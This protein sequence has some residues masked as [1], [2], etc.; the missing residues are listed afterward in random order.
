MLPQLNRREQM[1]HSRSGV[2]MLWLLMSFFYQKKGRCRL[3]LRGPGRSYIATCPRP[4]GYANRFAKEATG[5]LKK[6]RNI[7]VH[8]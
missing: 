8:Q 4:R 5:P 1:K 3:R 7:V 2:P 6:K